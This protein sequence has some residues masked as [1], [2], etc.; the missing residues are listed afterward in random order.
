M[1]R[2]NLRL[3]FQASPYGSSS[4]VELFPRCCN[5][6]SS[7]SK[8]GSCTGDEITYPPEA[9][10]PRSRIRHRSEQNGK[11]A[12]VAS[13]TFR[14]VGQNKPLGTLIK[15]PSLPR[16]GEVIFRSICGRCIQF[17]LVFFRKACRPRMQLLSNPDIQTPLERLIWSASFHPGKLKILI[18][19]PPRV[20]PLLCPNLALR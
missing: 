6:S 9:H 3:C 4:F 10:F 15:T 7:S 12:S 5:P 17:D 20:F 13:T 14:H 16:L 2:R 8:S 11:S 18:N 19:Y 1:K